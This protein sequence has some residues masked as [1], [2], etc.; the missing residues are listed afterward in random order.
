MMVNAI[1]NL[2]QSIVIWERSLKEGLSVDMLV[3]D[4]AQI[5]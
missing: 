2:T 1:V 3:E 4:R 5:V